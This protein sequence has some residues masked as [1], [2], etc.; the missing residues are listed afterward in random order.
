[1]G[2]RTKKEKNNFNN[3]GILPH[4]SMIP[5]STMFY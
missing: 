3:K 1:M 5:K 2:Q 4:I